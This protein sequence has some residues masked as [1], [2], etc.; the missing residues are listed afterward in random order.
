MKK[1]IWFLVSFT[2]VFLSARTLPELADLP[3]ID[4]EKL[5]F[6]T[7]R[8]LDVVTWNIQN[9]PKAGDTTIVYVGH[10]MLAM[11]ADI[12]ALQ[13]IQSD[14]SFIQLRNYMNLLD[15]KNK[16]HSY[17]AT[18]DQRW[19]M[20]V[21]YL[22][23][24]DISEYVVFNEIYT[25]D[26]K[27]NKYAFPRYPLVMRFVYKNEPIYLLNNHLKARGTE[28]DK[29]KRRKAIELLDL[30]IIT[31]LDNANVII[32]GDMNDQVTKPKEENVFTVFLNKPDEYQFVNYD[33][34]ADPNADWSYPYWKYRGFLD[35][36]VITNEL[37]DNFDY[38]KTIVIDRYME[39]GEDVRY[40]MIGDHRPVGARFQFK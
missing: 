25:E 5:S 29:A 23:K 21:A 18:S 28:E 27:E 7:E 11:D 35:N 37:F 17:R 20:N 3:K 14:S 8:T 30:H 22:F 19:N 10:I 12:F 36:I 40:K 6:G 9:F 38:V 26:S 32:L 31:F 4:F 2:Y 24:A 15:T 1:M 39:G 33:L 13:E 16:W 34:A